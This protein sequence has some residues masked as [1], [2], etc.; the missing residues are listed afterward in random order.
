MIELP[1]T[2]IFDSR[3]DQLHLQ[4]RGRIGARANHAAG[5]SLR[6]GRFNP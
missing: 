3:R 6:A 2:L 5:F 4:A 1:T